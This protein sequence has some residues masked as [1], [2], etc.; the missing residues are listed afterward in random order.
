MLMEA[1][2]RTILDA[3]V[4]VFLCLPVAL[5]QS[6]IGQLAFRC[7][8][9]PVVENTLKASD[10]TF[11]T[12]ASLATNTTLAVYASGGDILLVVFTPDKHACPFGMDLVWNVKQTDLPIGRQL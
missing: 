4:A 10:Y 11:I 6:K 2:M 9:I 12:G 3:L 5:A 7:H 1:V 8:P